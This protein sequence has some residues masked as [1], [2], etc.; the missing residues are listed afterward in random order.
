MSKAIMISISPHFCEKIATNE[1][2][3]I[4]RKTRPKLE[5][6][7]K[8]YIYCTQGKIKDLFNISE[9]TYN[10]RQ[11]VI[12]EFICNRIVCSQAY[13]DSQGKNH[14]TNVF[15][16]DIKRTCLTEYEMWNYIAGKAVKVNEMYDGYLW[17]I[18]DLKIYDKPKELSEFTPVCKDKGE[19][20]DICYFN[21]YNFGGCCRRL[22]RPPQ[23]W[24][25][26]ED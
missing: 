18:S 21:E 9:K 4:V 15:P 1:C 7:F 19:Q 5:T 14:L 2:S 3:I 11:K 6:P 26:I 25:H 10:N 13:F 16:E 17:H 12:G 8:C 20:C 24:C 22:T 23:S